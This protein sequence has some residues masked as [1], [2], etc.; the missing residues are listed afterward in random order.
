[1]ARFQHVA[2][3]LQGLVDSQQ[4]LIAG[5]LFLQ[6]RVD[7]GEEREGLPGFVDTLL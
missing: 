4:L 7:L 3:M 5:A 6:G 1:V 2:E